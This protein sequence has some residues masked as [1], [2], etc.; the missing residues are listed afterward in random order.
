M[1]DERSEHVEGS[2]IVH[3]KGIGP[4]GSNRQVLQQAIRFFREQV[5]ITRA[6]GGIECIMHSPVGLSPL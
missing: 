4:V 2:G 1:L 5:T 3:R 6:G